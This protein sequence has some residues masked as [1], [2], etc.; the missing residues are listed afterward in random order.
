MLNVKGLIPKHIASSQC[1]K[2]RHDSV[3]YGYYIHEDKEVQM[4]W[5]PNGAFGSWGDSIRNHAMERPNLDAALFGLQ[6]E[7][8][9]SSKKSFLILLLQERSIP[10][11]VML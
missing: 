11:M 10:R 8:D 4:T 7:F 9:V 2:Q 1:H 5:R 3:D 6:C